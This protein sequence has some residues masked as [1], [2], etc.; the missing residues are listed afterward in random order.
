MRGA[1]KLNEYLIIGNNIWQSVN[2]LLSIIKKHITIVKLQCAYQNLYRLNYL[3]FNFSL[4]LK[5]SSST[6]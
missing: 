6:N 4:T 2:N 1:K 5:M 3:F